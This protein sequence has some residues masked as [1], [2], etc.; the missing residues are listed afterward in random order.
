MI[1]VKVPPPTVTYLK[2]EEFEGILKIEVL[3]LY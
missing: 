3:T 1:T 2:Q